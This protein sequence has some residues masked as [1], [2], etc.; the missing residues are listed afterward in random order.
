L[1]ERKEKEK[2]KKDEKEKDVLEKSGKCIEIEKIFICFYLVNLEE[3][4]ELIFIN[5]HIFFLKF[6]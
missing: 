5:I 4:I 1:I 6:L 3:V 2:E